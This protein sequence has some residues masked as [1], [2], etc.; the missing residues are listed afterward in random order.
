MTRMRF[1]AVPGAAADA[2]ICFVCTG[3]LCRSPMAEVIL[4]EIAERAG[5]AE[6][7][8]VGSGGTGDWH[9]GEQADAR[10]VAALERRGYTL[11]AHRAKQFDVEWIE[12]FDLIVTFDRS[13]TRAIEAE[14]RQ[15]SGAPMPLVRSLLSFDE[16]FAEGAEVPDPYYG[17]AALFDEVCGTI[18]QACERLFAQFEP[19]IRATMTPGPQPDHRTAE[20]HA[21]PGSRHLG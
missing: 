8:F 6:R 15:R 9:V 13:Q 18:E 3:N 10:T 4:R 5:L 20:G 7:V 12:L 17:D 1:P 21:A 11:A 16:R 2:R 14:L 19:A